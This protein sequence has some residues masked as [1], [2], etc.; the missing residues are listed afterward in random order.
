[1]GHKQYVYDNT[2][3]SMPSLS[4]A[5]SELQAE[6][7]VIAPTIAAAIAH[8]GLHPTE[9]VQGSGSYSSTVRLLTLQG[10]ERCVLKIPYTKHKLYREIGALEALVDSLPVPRV[11]DVWIPDDDTPGAMLLSYLPGMT[12]EGPATPAQA[13]QMGALLAKIHE[14]RLARFG[15]VHA[16]NLILTAISASDDWWTLMVQRFEQWQAHCE[17]V[18][19]ADLY[20]ACVDVYH[21]IAQNLPEPDGPC[22]T[23]HDYRPGNILT[24][25][26]TITGIIDFESARAGSAD[27]DFTKM[28]HRLWQRS[29]ELKTAF[30]EGYVHVRALPPFERTLPFYQLHNAFGGI[31]WCARR[32]NQDDPFFAENLTVLRSLTACYA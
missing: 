2:G 10:G 32:T 13:R 12:V 6:T 25:G 7:G 27:L 8:F 9:I 23:H 4:P 16:A 19:P 11:L 21:A 22:W 14:H 1:M 24:V 5:I 15:E 28:S 3:E 31:A 18:L 17:A 20:A 26:E 30:L 29:P